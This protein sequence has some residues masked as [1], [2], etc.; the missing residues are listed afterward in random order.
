MTHLHPA[1]TRAGAEV[2]EGAGC[3]VP[4]RHYIPE[5]EKAVV[6]LPRL[7]KVR[8]RSK[9]PPGLHREPNSSAWVTNPGQAPFVYGSDVIGAGPS[10]RRKAPPL[11]GPLEM[12][13]SL[14]WAPS[15]HSHLQVWLQRPRERGVVIGHSTSACAMASWELAVYCPHRKRPATSVKD[16]PHALQFPACLSN[17]SKAEPIVTLAAVHASDWLPLVWLEMRCWVQ[18]P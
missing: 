15:S 8:A 11:P 13:A 4:L 16:P 7:G 6:T 18:H 17:K 10:E 14:L 2:L 12:L 1:V 3:G 9:P 5:E